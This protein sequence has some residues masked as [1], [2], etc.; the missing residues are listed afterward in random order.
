[1]PKAAPGSGPVRAARRG[2]LHGMP[3]AIACVLPCAVVLAILCAGGCALPHREPNPSFALPHA[4]AASDMRR[5]ADAPVRLDRPL[6]VLAGIGDPAVSSAAIVEA[7]R[8]CLVGTIV[9]VDFFN[10]HT[11]EGARQKL[12]REA[13]AA[14]FNTVFEWTKNR[15]LNR[16][17]GPKGMGPLDGYGIQ[18]LGHEHRQTMTMLNYNFPYYQQLVEAPTQAP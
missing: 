5:M 15:G 2:V 13:A 18:I 9:E 6:V 3:C 16:V 7:L 8:P 10:E 17:V 12:L 11:F 1:M 14:L 4:E